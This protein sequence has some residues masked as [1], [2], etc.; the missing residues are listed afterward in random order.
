MPRLALLLALAAAVCLPQTTQ[1]LLAGRVVDSQSGAPLAGAEIS[2][3]APATNASGAARPDTSGYYIL[4]LLSPG[5]YDL[6]AAAPGY[7]AQELRQLELPVAARLDLQ[8]RLR[9]L[10]D[11]WEAGQYRSVFLPNSEAV[12]TFYGPDVDT[13]RFGSFEATQGRRG[14]LESTVSEVIDPARIRDLPLAGR[15]AYTMLVTLPGVTADHATARGLGLSISGQRPSASNFLL[16]GLE[17][18]NHLVTG[19]LASLAPEAIQ[20]YRVSTSS[21]S[22]EYGRTAG[23]LANAVTR[24]G[25]AAWRALGYWYL[26]NDALNANGF[27][28]NRRG[29]ARPPLREHQYG[30]HAGGPLWSRRAL[31]VS[32]ALEHLRSRSRAEALDF[33][34]PSTRFADFTAPDSLARRLLAQFP[35][36]AA[37]DR[38][39]PTAR[40]T[41]APPVSVDRTLALE[42]LDYQPSASRHRLMGRLAIARLRRPDFIWTPYPDFV[43][44]LAQNTWSLAATLVSSLSPALTHE[45]RAGYSR[46]ELHWDR[47]HPEIPTLYSADGVYLPGSPAFYE[48]QNR[49]RS[50]EVSGNLLWARGRHLLKFGGGFLLRRVEGRL[51]A[52]RDALYVFG[53]ILDFS[54]DAPSFFSVSLARPSLP[55]FRL[56]EYPRQYRY[57][58]FHF[59]AQDTLRLAGRLTLN[60]GLRYETFGAPANTGPVKDA[61]VEPGAGRLSFPASGVQRLHPADRNN[62]A[63][64]FGFSYGLPGALLRGAYGFFYD[65]PFENLW[66]NLRTNSLVLAGFPLP[67]SRTDYLA[68][69][70]GVLRSYQ[71]RPFNTD[72]PA[73]TLLQPGLR[74]AYAQHY[75]FGI[76]RSLPG[77]WSVE[78]HTLG[79]L[80]RKLLTTDSINRPFSVRPGPGNPDG[81]LHPALAPLSYRANQGASNYH[82]L[83]LVARRR[84]PSRFFQLAYTWSHSIDNQSEP[85]AG[86]FFDLSF[87]RITS[88]TSRAA[89]AAFSRQFDSR[90]DRGSSDFDQRHNLVFYSLWDLPGG[91]RFSQLAAFRTG[92]PY[93]ITAPSRFS[94]DGEW[95]LNNRADVVAPIRETRQPV[96]G[97]RRLLD[98]ASFREPPPG[99]LGN[100]GRNL[101]SGPGLFNIDLSLSRSFRLRESLRLTLRADAFNFLNHANLNNPEPLLTSDRFGVALY[102]RKGRA[103]GFPAL[104][105][106]HESA[107]QF[108]LLLRLE[109]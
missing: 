19:P 40:L 20:E 106:L 35:A 102:G 77:E 8:F 21:F 41:L 75:F 63:L 52:G 104:T 93:S 16:D 107:R 31:F 76:Q 80:G 30:F 65:R 36:P 48:Y 62:A 18:N 88:G 37:A 94:L 56:P 42:R 12:V 10:S 90:A 69:V 15:D 24:S 67:F 17:N 81:R 11:V 44:P 6:R 108:Q 72:F 46:D 74:D 47:P 61:V 23:F 98:R 22:A 28:E 96:D 51:T 92:F 83:T 60:Y 68:P 38:N 66:Q 5:L 101:L 26:K 25:G 109:F 54:L 43:S 29:L 85:L 89:L 13:S 103:S 14:A 33:T 99:R 2:Y 34:F 9:P 7:Q 50:L 57:R 91:F 39:L 32:S 27:Q 58:Q 59:F 70:P 64:R 45:A 55:E 4:P 78:L 95:I 1:G 49:S 79:A 100:S 105:P 87:T 97:G 82:A 3:F 84:A 73:L 71:G 86:D 53:D